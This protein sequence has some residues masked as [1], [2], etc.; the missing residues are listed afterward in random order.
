M[1]SM[2]IRTLVVTF[3]VVTSVPEESTR[4]DRIAALVMQAIWQFHPVDASYLG[5]AK[6]DT[7]LA[8]YSKDARNSMVTRCR[9]FNRQLE[10]ID[11]S[12]L[13]I[14][15][16]IDLH[17]L[18]I[19]IAGELFALERTGEYEKNPLVYGQECVY[20]VY[21]MLRRR[22][23]QA[24]MNAIKKRLDQMPEFLNTAMRN[25]K[26]PPSIL[27][28]ITTEQL[29]QGEKLIE[30]F[31]AE[32]KSILAES[33][34]RAFQNSMNRAIAAIERF[35][36]WLDKNKDA[37]SSAALG[38][39]NYEYKLQHIHLLD[40]T[41]DSLLTVGYRYLDSLN[42]LIDSLERMYRKVPATRVTVSS[43]FGKRDVLAYQ[44]EEIAR[45]RDFVIDHDIV[46]VPEWI[47]DI[48]IVETPAFLQGVIPG[49]A[50]VPPAPY[51]TSRTSFFYT[52]P[53]PDRFD[54]TLTEYYYNYIQN[55]W[56]M[57]SV[58]HEAYPGHHLQLSRARVHPSEIRRGFSD[59]FFMEGWALYCEEL[60]ARSGLYEDSL[61]ALI[62]MLQ[63]IRF[64]A[65]RVIVDV[66]LQTGEFTYED[67][68][69]FMITEVHSNRAVA[70]K[71]VKRYITSPGQPSSYLIGKLQILQ[72]LNDYRAA[73]GDAF[74]LKE[75][76][77]DL[78]NHGS[79]P[80]SLVRRRMLP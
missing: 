79:I 47:G 56:F 53:V 8:D 1:G 2:I 39:E 24:T 73:R 75:F 51:D 63:G 5:M 7:L 16:Q 11:T 21:T 48:E 40:L 35:S 74:E 18:K 66:K 62:D 41:A 30:D 68:V 80:V 52:P 45:A 4:L 38:K 64:R 55:H 61:G 42:V 31:F 29:S 12:A 72:L 67:A 9:E 15:E 10:Q 65:G 78:L 33:E 70:A 13:S 59:Y 44:R 23:S 50:M 28:D 58:I 43:D 46:T 6:Y 37:E 69:E 76:H 3:F 19:Y 71:E 22:M 36:L 77:D 14:D 60:M 49:V 57:R 32:N 20:G 27:C 25:L 26:N 17:L 34:R 54:H